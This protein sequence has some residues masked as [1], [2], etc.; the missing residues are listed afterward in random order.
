V[1]LREAF[2]D[3]GV[4]LTAM[5]RSLFVGLFAVAAGA[6]LGAQGLTAQLGISDGRAREAVFDSLISG[7]VSVAGKAEVFTAA[8]PQ[9][10]VAMVNAALSI[11]RA[12]VESA[13]FPQRYADHRDANGPDPLPP[14]TTAAEVLA[15]QRAGFEAQVEG[16]RKQ[17]PELTPEQRKTLEEGF[18]AMR[19]RFDDMEKGDARSELD[20]ALKAQ[21][22]RQVQARETA[23]KEL[24]KTYPADPRALVASRLRAFLDLS[25]DID[26]T[27]A[28]VEKDKRMR[29][30]DPAL[31]A[32]PAEW[33]MLFRAGKPATDAARAF[34][35]KWLAQL[36]GKG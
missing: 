15:K 27:A 5:K 8:S 11:A 30:V 31:E 23:L 14:P 18:D 9:A 20:V 28:L 4:I 21:Y 26:F 34:A 24:E 19:A 3:S 1:F 16:M 6:A 22:A 29:F 2:A 13:E 35:Q 33:K 7:A 12:F 10:R 36:E 25:R 32:R 17:F